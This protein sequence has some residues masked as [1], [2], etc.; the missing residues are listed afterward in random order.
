ME[1]IDGKYVDTD[2]ATGTG[3]VYDPLTFDSTTGQMN[4]Y[5]TVNSYS[6]ASSAGNQYLGS[7]ASKSSR[8]TFRSTPYVEDTYVNSRL[9]SGDSS[10]MQGSN[11]VPAFDTGTYAQLNDLDKAQYLK[12]FNTPEGTDWGMKGV[13][14]TMIGVGQ[15]GLGIA[16]YL[17]SKRVNDQSIKSS[18]FNLAQAKKDAAVDDAYRASYGA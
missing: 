15:L 16:S 4:D 18:K 3:A 2:I 8:S 9:G 6:A 13:G 10:S 14:G 5:G 1:W 17:E 11:R 7:N 12:D